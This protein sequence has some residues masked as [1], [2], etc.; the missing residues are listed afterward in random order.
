LFSFSDSKVRFSLSQRF[1]FGSL[2][3]DTISYIEYLIKQPFKDEII[4]LILQKKKIIFTP[5][6][7]LVSVWEFSNLCLCPVPP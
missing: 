3:K 2:I 6:F 1:L 5:G 4:L 7:W